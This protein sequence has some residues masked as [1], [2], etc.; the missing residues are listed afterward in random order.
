MQAAENCELARWRRPLIGCNFKVE[1]RYVLGASSFQARDPHRCSRP[2]PHTRSISYD[3]SRLCLLLEVRG[4][5][6][7]N[8]S[9]MTPQVARVA[10]REEHKQAA[11][12]HDLGAVRTCTEVIFRYPAQATAGRSSGA[13]GSKSLSNC[14]HVSTIR[15]VMIRTGR[16]R[17]ESQT[18]ACMYVSP[19]SR[20]DSVFRPC[21]RA[22]GPAPAPFV[23]P[24][25]V[26]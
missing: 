18:A 22:L 17:C 9:W 10:Q 5:W 8:E 25:P 6:G 15:E 7:N 12:N 20:L 4:M 26:N 23:P 2:A 14:R 13:R 16:V 11:M 21:L 1:A 24:F 19:P 3:P